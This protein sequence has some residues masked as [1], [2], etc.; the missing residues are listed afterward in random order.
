SDPGRKPSHG[1]VLERSARSRTSRALPSPAFARPVQARSSPPE[2]L[3][4]GARV[5]AGL[6][7]AAVA[8]AARAAATRAGRAVERVGAGVVVARGAAGRVTGPAG[9]VGSAAGAGLGVVVAGRAAGR[10]V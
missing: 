7:V 10:A 1:G 6:R 4:T 5:G 3:G 8:G 2:P 9:V